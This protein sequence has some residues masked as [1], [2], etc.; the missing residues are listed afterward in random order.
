ME[1]RRFL[2]TGPTATVT[3]ID[4]TATTWRLRSYNDAGHLPR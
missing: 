1:T 4:A 3:E 2:A